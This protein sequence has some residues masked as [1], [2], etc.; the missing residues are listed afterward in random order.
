MVTVYNTPQHNAPRCTT[1]QQTV[2]HQ[3]WFKDTATHCNTLQHNKCNTLQ[4]NTTHCNTLQHT[5]THCN[6][7]QHCTCNTFQHNT[8]HYNTLRG[9]RYERPSLSRC[10]GQADMIPER[11]R[12]HLD[13]F[14]N[15]VDSVTN[16]Q[17]FGSAFPHSLANFP[18]VPGYR[19]VITI[20]VYIYIHA[21]LDRYCSTVQ[22]LLD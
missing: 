20:Y 9:G 17:L 7:V 18:F 15:L 1:P 6:I 12:P 14:A 16:R 8:T 13:I 21:F 10:L 11:S 22:G 5:A 19:R 2:S 4:H 3:A